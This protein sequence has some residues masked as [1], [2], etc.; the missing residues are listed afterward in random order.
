MDKKEL[1]LYVTPSQEIVDFELDGQILAGSGKI[2]GG[3]HWHADE[4]DELD[5][6]A[7]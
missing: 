6:D 5:E 2:G 4:L 7:E 3:G 1:K